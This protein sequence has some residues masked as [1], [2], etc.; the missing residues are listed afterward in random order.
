MRRKEL[1]IFDAK[2]YIPS[3]L[4]RIMSPIK[5]ITLLSTLALNS[6]SHR[7]TAIKTDGDSFVIPDMNAY[8]SSSNS[9]SVGQTIGAGTSIQSVSTV[10]TMD[11]DGKFRADTVVT[12]APGQSAPVIVTKGLEVYISASPQDGPS[13]KNTV[14]ENTKPKELEL[15][16]EKKMQRKTSATHQE[17][18]TTYSPGIFKTKYEQRHEKIHNTELPNK[19]DL[20]KI[21][22]NDFIITKIERGN[23][24]LN[25]AAI[26]TFSENSDTDLLKIKLGETL[27]K[28]LPKVQLRTSI[29]LPPSLWVPDDTATYA[30]FLENIQSALTSRNVAK[31][32][33]RN[34]TNELL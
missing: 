21:L 10:V 4:L 20:E 34:D 24:Y 8:L 27:L 25:Y 9:F 28:Y 14:L 29:Y 33:P 5:F 31:C 26:I 1:L 15:A 30:Q 23:E 22:G 11:K 18:R 32:G 7:K 6:F 13:E 16:A 12:V 3:F 17:S 2:I 19:N